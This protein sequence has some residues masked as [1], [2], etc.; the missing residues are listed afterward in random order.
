VFRDNSFLKAPEVKA[1]IANYRMYLDAYIDTIINHV[2][3][4][5]TK[6]TQ[7]FY[8]SDEETVTDTIRNVTGLK[9][10]K[11]WKLSLEKLK[12][13][14]LRARFKARLM[15]KLCL[16]IEAI[17]TGRITQLS[18]NTSMYP[19]LLTTVTTPL[20]DWEQ[21]TLILDGS[22]DLS[23]FHSYPTDCIKVVQSQAKLLPVK[24]RII[25]VPSVVSKY[26][27]QK[28]LK[29]SKALYTQ[30]L[31]SLLDIALSECPGPIYYTGYKGRK[32]E[33]EPDDTIL[34]VTFKV[35]RHEDFDNI[36]YEDKS[37]RRVRVSDHE[38]SVY[39]TKKIKHLLSLE[40]DI[41]EGQVSLLTSNSHLESLPENPRF[42]LSYY[43]L[44]KGSNA[45]TAVT[46]FVSQGF[47][48]FPGSVYHT[49]RRN[50]ITN[51][52]EGIAAE[53]L[54]QEVMR[55]GIRA[56][57]DVTLILGDDRIQIDKDNPGE[58]QVS[59][60][61]QLVIDKLKKNHEVNLIQKSL[62]DTYE[63]AVRPGIKL[64]IKQFQENSPRHWKSS[65]DLLLQLIN[66]YPVIIESSQ[67]SNPGTGVVE[68]NVQEFAK[69]LNPPRSSD[70][71]LKSIRKMVNNSSGYLQMEITSQARN[72]HDSTKIRF[73]INHNLIKE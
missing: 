55:T 19:L 26:D 41:P 11:E 18:S 66:H 32:D 1:L 52:M 57:K 63:L 67:A 70:H 49:M 60:P 25:V 8:S 54:Y 7:E 62:K 9:I 47:F 48:I 42:I 3:D 56:G 24:V 43:G 16:N 59:R 36:H 29:N 72:Q 38:N 4:I 51:D 53:E 68:I 39:S 31:H 28:G 35:S 69:K 33:L 40:L 58:Y 12:L 46:N 21:G 50:K 14:K 17:L 37:E 34:S 10:P 64:I 65:K 6:R 2:I 22:A 71:L 15:Y 27:V 30:Y 13:N 44:M 23:R 20:L 45:F 73:R 5:E 61:I